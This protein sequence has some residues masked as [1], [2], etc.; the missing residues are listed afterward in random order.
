MNRKDKN[1]F[2]MLTS[3]VNCTTNVSLFPKETAGEI[4]EA[5]A[6][7]VDVLSEAAVARR[8][9]EVAIREA[10]TVQTAAREDLKDLLGRAELVSRA[11]HSDKLR[12]PRKG[13]DREL[14]TIGRSFNVDV[15]SMKP[16]FVRH[17][18]P[19]ERVAVTVD[20]LEAAAAQYAAAKSSKAAAI[21]RWNAAMATTLDTLVSLDAL[22]ATALEDN[23]EAM[24]AYKSARTILRTRGKAATATAPE[25]PAVP[26]AANAAVA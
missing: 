2:E 19:I 16:G 13:T 11:L 23:P 26:A 14:I 15:E 8:S 21:R 20:A 22:V 12:A 4:V 9:A 18:F 5:L 25:T 7:G 3:V 17:R 6:S 24:A 10:R 1:N